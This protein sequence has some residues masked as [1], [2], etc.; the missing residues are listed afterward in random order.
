MT[1]SHDVVVLGCGLMGSALARSFANSGCS[2][3]AWNR[4][5]DRAAA[6]AADGVHAIADIREA[7]AAAPLVITCLIDYDTTLAALAHV[8]DLSGKT[9]V[10]LGS[11]TPEEVAAFAAA[12]AERGA[13]S[14][15]GSIICYPE[16]IGTEEGAII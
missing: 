13:E 8:A 6:L 7:V 3:G 1:E 2:T 16:S 5:H 14:I 11:E 9:V 12:M 15:D 10:N 4:T